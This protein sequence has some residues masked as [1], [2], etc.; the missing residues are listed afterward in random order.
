MPSKTK[1]K[2]IEWLGALFTITGDTGEATMESLFWFGPDGALLG[3]TTA[4]VGEGASS[5][6]ASLRSTM[7][8]PMTGRPHR[9]DRVRIAS[10]EVAEFLRAGQSEVE[11]VC[12][13]TPEVDARVAAL[14]AQ[15]SGKGPPSYLRMDAD[16]VQVG[17]FCRAAASLF[18][19]KPWKTVPNHMCL[20][21][22]DIPALSLYDG[23][24]SVVGQQGDRPGLLLFSSLDDV[25]AYGEACEALAAGEDTP[26][27]PHLALSFSR[28]ADLKPSLIREIESH[29]WPVAS[30]AAYPLLEAVGDDFQVWPPSALDLSTCAA[31]C[32]ALVK[33][34]RDEAKLAAAWE[35]R[36][37]FVRSLLVS[38]SAGDVEVQLRAPYP[39]PGAARELPGDLLGALAA[40]ARRGGELDPVAREPLE[41]ELVRQFAASP[42]A[43]ALPHVEWC[44]LLMDLA[45]GY[46]E[47]TVATLSATELRRL[48][49]ELIPRKVSVDASAARPMIEEYRAFYTF[50][51]RAF[52]LT[53]AP[54]CLKVLGGQAAKKLEAAMSNPRAFGMGKAL[55]MMARDAGFEVGTES[56]M[57]TWLRVMQ[58][59]PLS[60]NMGPALERNPRAPAAAPA[61]TRARKPKAGP[62]RRAR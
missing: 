16:P 28:A 30:R 51:G 5:A 12:A 8:A 34:L 33:A 9:P 19:A 54:A 10:P 31:I 39:E 7:A 41:A 60:P 15:A 18:R 52:G 47:A 55:F 35:G 21:A 37:P 17:D 48:V 53:Q 26:P 1:R 24:L 2:P 25:D 49:F 23:V 40:L 3:E 22:V 29:H 6:V 62:P 32:R 58:S 36:A 46:F 27:P 59:E 4:P 20:V 11:V 38:T 57:E 42:E 56:G 13:P 44:H 14:R 43:Q 50:L 45:A 61:K